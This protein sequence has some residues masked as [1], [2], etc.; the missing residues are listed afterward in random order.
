MFQQ[1]F[2]NNSEPKNIT[3]PCLPGGYKTKVTGHR[4][5]VTENAIKKSDT[6][7]GFLCLFICCISG[8][9]TIRHMFGIEHASRYSKSKRTNYR[10][11]HVALELEECFL[12]F[13]LL[14]TSKRGFIFVARER[15]WIEVLRGECFATY[16]LYCN[17]SC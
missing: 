4:S 13:E 7:L 11:L 5:Q 14:E 9:V 1:T 15:T 2:Y 8:Y 3:N 12:S 17:A 16:Q 10:K 6:L